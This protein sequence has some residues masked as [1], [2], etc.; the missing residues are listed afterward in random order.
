MHI[1]PATSSAMCPQKEFSTVFLQSQV[2]TFRSPDPWLFYTEA[3]LSGPRPDSELSPQSI[4]AALPLLPGLCLR[5]LTASAQKPGTVTG[6][7]PVTPQCINTSVN[8]RQP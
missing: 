4:E 1:H 6:V 7:A 8:P 5:L 3:V 2:N